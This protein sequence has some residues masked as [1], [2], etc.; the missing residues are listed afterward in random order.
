[1]PLKTCPKCLKTWGPRKKICSCGH[2]FIK[3]KKGS[4]IAAVDGE[5]DPGYE[6]ATEAPP[7]TAV[8]SDPS[9]PP[10]GYGPMVFDIEDRSIGSLG[11]QFLLACGRDMVYAKNKLDDIHEMF[12]SAPF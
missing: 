4:R 5:P 7:E 6:P 8:R 10:V 9:A 12:I 2:V 3:D 11:L 1:M